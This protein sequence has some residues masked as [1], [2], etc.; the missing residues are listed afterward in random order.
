MK[1]PRIAIVGVG[2]GGKIHLKSFEK[3]GDAEICA[4]VA[5]SREANK[6]FSASKNLNF[7]S[8]LQDC[9]KNENPDGVIIAS[10]NEYHF[11]HSEI[12]ISAG[13][14]VLLEKPITSTLESGQEL[15][16]LVNQSGSKFLVGH[17]RAHNPIIHKAKEVISSGVLGEL[18]SFS[19]SAQFYKPDDYFELGSWRKKIGGGPAL[20]NLIHEID[21]MRRLFG[22]IEAVQAIFSSN[23]RS[24]EV[25]DTAVINIRFVN[26]ALGSMTLS[27]AASTAKS[28][29]LTSG[30]NPNYIQ[31][32]GEDCYHISGT[33]GS[34][35]VPTM[36]L[37]YF[38]EEVESSWWNPLSQDTIEVLK[39][40]PIDEQRDHFLN[41][42]KG[43][44]APLV[45]IEDGCKNLSVLEAIKES[46]QIEALVKLK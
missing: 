8:S 21:I 37:K 5:P 4:L 28:W 2:L 32:S 40:D 11:R 6:E 17:H 42:I 1:L 46:A 45:T 20:I 23:I 25:E 31:Y 38:Q 27:D 43:I 12:C 41:V 14:P 26:G 7:Y 29:E 15:M 19:G 24:F 30:E 22:E 16:H 3:C 13:L 44:E 34:L 36:R 35:G 9:F 39:K 18:V 10:P 33:R